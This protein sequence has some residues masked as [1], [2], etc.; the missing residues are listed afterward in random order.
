MRISPGSL[1]IALALALPAISRD[2]LAVEGAG[3]ESRSGAG[4]TYVVLD[5]DLKQLRED[6]NAGAGKVRLVFVVG[7]T[8]GVCL[9]G[10]VDLNDAFL[11]AMQDEDR[12]HTFVVHVP[13]LGARENHVPAAMTLLDG[14]RISHYWDALGTIGVRYREVLELPVYAWD[15]WML[16]GG[17]ATWDGELPPAPEFW[18]HQLG[19]SVIGQRLDA[20]EFRANLESRLD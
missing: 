11:A 2:A 10:M 9:R 16:Y 20:E 4:G 5:E 17:E 19:R 15:V 3:A 13:T 7:P 1:L 6:F 14:P 12:L 18:Q 8:C